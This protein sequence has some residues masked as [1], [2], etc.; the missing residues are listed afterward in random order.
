MTFCVVFRNLGHSSF[1]GDDKT[2]IC[3]V[4]FRFLRFSQPKQL[5]FAG[6][7]VQLIGRPFQTFDLSVSK[8]DPPL[9]GKKTES[10]IPDLKWIGKMV[11][12][13]WQ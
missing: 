9:S 7:S 2:E 5:V 13:L 4:G 12:D 8:S 10:R 11:S 6:F 1:N 3:G